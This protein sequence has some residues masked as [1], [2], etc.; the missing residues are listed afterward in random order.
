[1]KTRITIIVVQTM[2]LACSSLDF[3]QYREDTGLYA[4]EKPSGY[5]SSKFGARLAAS[6]TQDEAYMAVSAGQGT[7]TLFYRLSRDNKLVNI[8]D[9]QADYP[10]D[11]T[12]LT[13][14]DAVSR[15]SGAALAGLPVFTHN[16]DTVRGCLAVGEPG[17]GE[18][19]LWCASYEDKYITLNGDSGI[20]NFGQILAPIRREGGAQFLLAVGGRN[21]F[22]L[23]SDTGSADGR[24]NMAALL[25]DDEILIALAGG[26]FSPADGENRIFTAASVSND[27]TDASSVYIYVQS[28]ADPAV[29]SPEA[30]LENSDDLGFGGAVIARDLDGDG[31]DELV[32]GSS[33]GAEKS[34]VGVHIFDVA[35]VLEAASGSDGCVNVA[36]DEIP[37][38]AVLEPDGEDLD[39]VCEG[40][41]AFGSVLAAGDIAV[42]DDGPE[43]IVGASRADVKGVSRAGAVYIFRGWRRTDGEYRDAALVGQ[44]FDSTPERGKEFG[45]GAAVAAMAGRNELLVSATGEGKVFVAFCTGVGEDINEGA[46]VPDDANGKV[47]STRCRL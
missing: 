4:V 40:D 1:M 29:F 26:R 3:L 5:G 46:D 44:V 9:S 15:G 22:Q 2:L 41:C 13:E 16:G 39:A 25:N 7:S 21:G 42:D 43:L 6:G 12:A 28:S 23:F 36:D 47:V 37:T 8:T 45:A 19:T 18:V 35:A 27:E 17:E 38:L 20:S 32:V 14:E 33:A 31:A 11:A 34:A 24:S 10:D 30:C